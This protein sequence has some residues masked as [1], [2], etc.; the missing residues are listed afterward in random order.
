MEFTTLYFEKPGD[1]NTDTTLHRAIETALQR[2]MKTLVV[3]SR[4]GRTA[5]KLVE[6]LHGKDIR[7][8]V[9]TPQ[10]GW[11]DTHEFDLSLVP[12]LREKGHA[13][14]T[15]SM[16]FH[17][18]A[19]HGGG[20]AEAMAK[21]LRIFGHGTQVCVEIGMMAV[22][23]GHVEGGK[24]CICIAGTRRGAD[25]AIIVTPSST[26][27]FKDFLVHEFICRPLLRT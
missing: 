10:F 20:E 4:S 21:T 1:H 3:A 11:H 24:E 26:L 17:M 6:R 9:I 18:G 8:V 23:G 16:P 27:R 22:D 13:F 19:F 12:R 25:T 2:D 7:T 15:G 14:H 5:M